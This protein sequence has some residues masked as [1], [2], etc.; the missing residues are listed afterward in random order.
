MAKTERIKVTR[1]DHRNT[2][3]QADESYNYAIATIKKIIE[4][5]YTERGKTPP[6]DPKLEAMAKEYYQRYPPH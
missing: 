3:R 2:V 4:Q 6:A 1:A 5:R